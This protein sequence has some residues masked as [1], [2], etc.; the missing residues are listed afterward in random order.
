MLKVA[1]L[2]RLLQATLA[3]EAEMRFCRAALE[4]FQHRAR[5]MERR[6]REDELIDRDNRLV[7][8]I[9]N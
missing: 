7:D 8:R 4:V 9:V 1:A 2:A 5:R 6:V 3:R